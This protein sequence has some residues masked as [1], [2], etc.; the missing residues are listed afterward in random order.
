MF[1]VTML[2]KFLSSLLFLCTHNFALGNSSAL[3][4]FSFL[5]FWEILP[6]FLDSSHGYSLSTMKYFLILNILIIFSLPLSLSLASVGTHPYCL[7]YYIYVGLYLSCIATSK[8]LNLSGIVSSSKCATKRELNWLP[9]L[10]TRIHILKHLVRY[11]WV[12]SMR[13]LT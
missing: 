13:Q 7:Y 1:K 11:L 4:S 2:K 6:T 5:F 9:H 3:N 12:I 10:R 8:T